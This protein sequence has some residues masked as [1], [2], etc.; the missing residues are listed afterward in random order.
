MVGHKGSR[1]V[2]GPWPQMQLLVKPQYL[3]PDRSVFELCRPVQSSVASNTLARQQQDG[4]ARG[5]VI[6][7]EL[8]LSNSC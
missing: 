3:L 6:A 5:E 7:R 2:V 4:N 8:C 1:H